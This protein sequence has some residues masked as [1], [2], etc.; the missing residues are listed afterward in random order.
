M[1]IHPIQ[2]LKIW[3]E[4]HQ[5]ILHVVMRQQNHCLSYNVVYALFFYLYLLLCIILHYHGI[6]NDKKNKTA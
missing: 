3:E 1:I 2:S 4:T 5:Y 6:I